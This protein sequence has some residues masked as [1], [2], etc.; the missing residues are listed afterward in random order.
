[1]SGI[2]ST[3]STAGLDSLTE[4]ARL[5]LAGSNEAIERILSLARGAL[6]MDVALV[7]A[8]DGEYVIEAAEAH[9]RLEHAATEE[10]AEGVFPRMRPV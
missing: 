1:M 9:R 3:K 8:F 10:R 5:S 4:L 7:G 6:D 2:I